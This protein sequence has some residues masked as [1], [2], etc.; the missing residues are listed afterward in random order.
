VHE[1]ETTGRFLSANAIRDA[2]EGAGREVG[3][4]RAVP[5]P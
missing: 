4:D 3:D 2:I 1:V 5:R